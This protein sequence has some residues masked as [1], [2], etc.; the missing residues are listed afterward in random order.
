MALG[1]WKRGAISLKLSCM[2]LAGRQCARVH[3]CMARQCR[4]QELHVWIGLDLVVCI[5]ASAHAC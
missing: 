2:L 4:K 1:A 3:Q 5:D